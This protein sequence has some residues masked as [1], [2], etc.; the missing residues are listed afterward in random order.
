MNQMS[1]L[2]LDRTSDKN[3]VLQEP[4]EAVR[5]TQCSDS[6]GGCRPGLRLVGRAGWWESKVLDSMGRG[7]FQAVRSSWCRDIWGFSREDCTVRK[8]KKCCSSSRAG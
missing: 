8:R 7:V 2:S 4:W 1:C 5:G 6:R 3:G